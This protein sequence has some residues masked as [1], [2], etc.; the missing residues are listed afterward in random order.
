[1]ITKLKRTKTPNNPG[2]ILETLLVNK[3]WGRY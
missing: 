3:R 2:G 1:M